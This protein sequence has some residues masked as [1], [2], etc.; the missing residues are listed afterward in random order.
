M[1]EVNKK[2]ILIV[3]DSIVIRK[4]ISGFLKNDY[5]TIEAASPSECLKILADT[6]PKIDLALIDVVMPEMYGFK[7]VKMIKKHPSYANV[8]CLMITTKSGKENIN[9]AVLA[10]ASGY[11]GKPFDKETI[12]KKISKHLK[13]ESPPHP[14]KDAP[15]PSSG[16]DAE[17]KKNEE[18][19]KDK[20]SKK[21]IESKNAEGS[22]KDEESKNDENDISEQWEFVEDE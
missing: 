10:G 18:T 4:M 5:A 3:D 19:K 11:I 7:L 6:K 16:K 15:P 2:T 13:S 1:N 12:I 22:K 14:Q 9:K 17:S 21:E 20:A 8:P